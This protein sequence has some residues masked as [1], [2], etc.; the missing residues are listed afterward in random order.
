MLLDLWALKIMLL[1][2]WALKIM[3]LDLWA[4]K[5]MLLDLWAL[6]IMLLDLWALHLPVP[7]L[8][9]DDDTNIQNKHTAIKKVTSRYKNADNS[10][11][12]REH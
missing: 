10:C 1:D 3:L 4:L 6:K 8:T 5:I 7:A 12:L 11:S 2:I 9:L